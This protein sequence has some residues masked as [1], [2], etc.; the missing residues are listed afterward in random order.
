MANGRCH[1]VCHFCSV[2]G[3]LSWAGVQNLEGESD[4]GAV[5]LMFLV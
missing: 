1:V 5:D 4:I 2:D 3:V